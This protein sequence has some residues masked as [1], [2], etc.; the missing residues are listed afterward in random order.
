MDGTYCKYFDLKNIELVLLINKYCCTS[1]GQ[2]ITNI[3]SA[4]MRLHNINWNTV[5]QNYFERSLE[6]PSIIVLSLLV[7]VGFT[8]ISIFTFI[9]YFLSLC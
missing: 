3:M 7:T 6:H 1:D 5:L 2:N 8:V 9:F 4:G